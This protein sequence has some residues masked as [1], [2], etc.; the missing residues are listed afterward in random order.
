[1][2]VCVCV[3]QELGTYQCLVN[4]GVV[5]V[6]VAGILEEVPEKEHITRNPL[7]RLDQEVIQRQSSMSLV[8]P[9]LLWLMSEMNVCVSLST[10]P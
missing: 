5:R 7:D 6:G 10:T 8:G 1:M 9:T 4:G 3:H 2:C